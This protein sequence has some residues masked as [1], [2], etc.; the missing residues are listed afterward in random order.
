MSDTNKTILGRVKIR[1]SIVDES[2]DLLLSDIIQSVT[3]N[4]AIRA[5]VLTFPAL[6]NSI[7]VDVSIAYYNRLGSEGL[8]SEGID[9]ISSN[10]ITDLLVPYDPQIDEF[11]Q[12]LSDND[13]PDKGVVFY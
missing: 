6:L 1:L 5:G 7:A 10:F 4:I 12:G 8:Q 3:D 9:V 13:M 11:K 2:K